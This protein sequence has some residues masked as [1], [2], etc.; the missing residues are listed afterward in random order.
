MASGAEVLVLGLGGMGSAALYQLA[1]RGISARGFEQF[2]LG[3][4]FGSSHGS[5][6]IIR[7]AYFEHSD[8]VPLLERAYTLWDEVCAESAQKLFHRSGIVIYGPEE[9]GEV[10]PGVLRSSQQYGIPLES[11]TR[12]EAVKRFPFFTPPE[13]SRAVFEPDAGYLEVENCVAAH[14]QLAQRHGARVHAQEK[15]LSWEADKNSVR[16]RTD[17]ATYEGASLV[18]AAGVWSAQFAPVPLSIKRKV[19]FW[20]DA[21]EIYAREKGCPCYFFDLPYGRIYGFPSIPGEGL[22]LADHSG[23]QW[24]TDPL[25]VDRDLLEGDHDTVSHCLADHF[26]GVLPEIRQHKVCLYEMSPDENFIIDRHPEHA[27]V[28][29]GAG[30]SGHGFKFASVVGEVLADLA[31][32]GKT[33]HPVDFLKHRWSC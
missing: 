2:S 29:Y 5:T 32:D 26:P 22:K 19:L 24:I 28:V 16:V 14:I 9:G 1:R 10:I 25:R 11:Y 20:H 7:K 12:E 21:P 3:H 23:G 33:R 27:N 31:V 8:Y 6:R 4:A 18:I 13:N 30:F 17:K 15:V